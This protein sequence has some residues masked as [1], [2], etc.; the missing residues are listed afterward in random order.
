MKSSNRISPGGNAFEYPVPRRIITIRILNAITSLKRGDPNA[1]RYRKRRNEALLRGNRQGHAARVRA[2]VCRRSSQLGGADALLRAPL[3]L[4]RFQRARLS[5]VGCAAG[6]H[7]VFAGDRHRRYRRR[8]A[9]SEAAQGPR[10]RLLDGGLLRAQLRHS[11]R[12]AYAVGDGSRRRRGFA[13]RAAPRVPAKRRSDREAL[14][15]ARHEGGIAHRRRESRA[16]AVSEQG[17]ARLR[18]IL[19]PA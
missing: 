13:S 19:E 17:P 15:R 3:S 10:R 12:R 1:L 7:E 2:R 9:A 5:A 11:L 14:R 8:D 4:R 16:R 6:A 18:R